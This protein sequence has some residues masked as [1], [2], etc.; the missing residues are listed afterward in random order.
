MEQPLLTPEQHEWLHKFLG[1]NFSIEYKPWKDNL[2]VDASSRLMTLSWSKPQC[3]FIQEVKV[4]LQ[5]DIQLVEIMQKCAEQGHSQSHYIVKED[6][7]YW[8]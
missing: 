1:Y 4:A 2:P 8:K 6:L 3:N 7:L 5:T